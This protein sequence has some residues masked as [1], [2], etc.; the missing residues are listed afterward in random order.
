M[1]TSTI[2]SMMASPREGHVKQLYHMFAYLW[3]KQNISLVFDTSEPDIDESQFPCED[4]IASAYGECS[5]DILPNMPKPCGIGFTMLNC[6]ESD[7]AIE[8]TTRCSRT[9]FIIYLNSALM[10]WF[11]KC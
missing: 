2:A 5:E 3:I 11:S 6:V 10:Y 9:G 8:L 4:W 1:E 7:H